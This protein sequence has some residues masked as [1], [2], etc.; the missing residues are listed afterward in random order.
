MTNRFERALAIA[1]FCLP[2]L[3]GPALALSSGPAMPEYNDFES[4]DNTDLVNLV[5]GDMA[6]TIPVMTVP[7]PGLGFPIVLNYHS[8]IQPEQEASWVG[9]GWNLEAGAIT[10]QVNNVPDDFRRTPI[11][12]KITS[13]QI[14]GWMASIAWNGATVGISWDSESGLGG[15]VGYSYGIEGAPFQVGGTAGVNGVY[16]GVGVTLGARAMSRVGENSA[17]GAG[18]NLGVHSKRGFTAGVSA[19]VSLTS[20]V[21]SGSDAVHTSTSLASVGVSLSSSKGPSAGASAGV[22]FTASASV[23][24][25]AQNS[26][27]NVWIPVW[28]PWTG[29][30]EFNF[31]TWESYIDGFQEDRYYGFLYSDLEGMECA[32]DPTRCYESPGDNYT[33]CRGCNAKL[34]LKK[35]D[36]INP[37]EYSRVPV[38]PQDQNTIDGISSAYFKLGYTGEDIYSVQTQGISGTFRPYRTEDGEYYSYV[39]NQDYAFT[40]GCKFIGG[41]TIGDC[42][43]SGTVEFGPFYEGG[44]GSLPAR[45]RHSLAASGRSRIV[46]RFND[47]RGGALYTDPADRGAA[48]R[49]AS[50][51]RRIE[52]IFVDN[53]IQGWRVTKSDGARYLYANAQYNYS[54]QTVASTTS[55]LAQSTRRETPSYAYAWLLTA[56]LSPDYVAVGDQNRTCLV[57]GSLCQPRDGDIGGW[58]KFTYSDP[59]TVTWKTPVDRGSDVGGWAPNLSPEN[60]VTTMGYKSLSYLDAIETPSHIATMQ[61]ADNS[62]KDGIPPAL[63]EVGIPI[64]T[65]TK[66]PP[67][68]QPPA[69]PKYCT[70]TEL[71]TLARSNYLV[72]IPNA[73]ETLPP[74]TQVTLVAR[75]R[76]SWTRFDCEWNWL[77]L[78]CGQFC[79]EGAGDEVVGNYV[80]PQPVGNTY[81]LR[82]ENSTDIESLR[83][84][85]GRLEPGQ[86]ASRLAYLRGITLKNKAFGTQ[87]Q[88]VGAVRFAYDYSLAQNTPNSESSKARG[89]GGDKGR[90]TLK[91]VQMGGTSQGPWTPPYTFAY[92]STLEGDGTEVK[93]H[94]ERKDYWGYQCNSC[95]VARRR[96][97]G[98]A[99]AW[100]LKRITHPS[101]SEIEF[102][103]EPKTA[104]YVE[105]VPFLIDGDDIGNHLGIHEDYPG[106]GPDH[107]NAEFQDLG[108][109][110]RSIADYFSGK[111]VMFLGRFE[112][113]AK[114]G[115][116]TDI[117]NFSRV[118]HHPAIEAFRAQN[119]SFPAPE[120]LVEGGFFPHSDDQFR[121]GYGDASRS[122]QLLSATPNGSPAQIVGQLKSTEF[123]PAKINRMFP[124]NAWKVRVWAVFTQRPDLRNYQ[125]G[126]RVSEVKFNEPFAGK[127]NFVR[128]KYEDAATP[129]LPESFSNYELGL[130]HRDATGIKAYLGCPAILHGKVTAAY[131]ID[132]ARQYAS[133]YN[134]VTSRDL[135]VLVNSVRPA[136]FVNG[137]PLQARVKILDRS[138]LW[139]SLWRKVDRDAGNAV[140]REATTS[141]SARLAEWR[142]PMLVRPNQALALSKD[143][144]A[145]LSDNDSQLKVAGEAE[146]LLPY[147]GITQKLWSNRFLPA[148]CHDENSGPHKRDCLND[149]LGAHAAQVELLRFSPLRRKEHTLQ[150][151]LLTSV[152]SNRFD[153][154][155]GEPL[156]SIS[157]NRTGGGIDEYIATL[158]APAFLQPGT[159]YAAMK[160]MNM[161]DQQFSKTVFRFTENPAGKDFA[162]LPQADLDRVV[163]SEVTPWIDLPYAMQGQGTFSRFRNAESFVLKDRAGFQL[164]VPGGLTP[165]K[166][167]NRGGTE[168]FD[169]FGHAL[170][171][172]S[173][174]GHRSAQVWG[175]RSTLP[176]AFAQNAK[177]DEIFYQGFETEE[178]R[179]VIRSGHAN[180]ALEKKWSRTGAASLRVVNC[181]EADG[182]CA[183]GDL[184]TMVCA[185]LTGLPLGKT[186][187]ASAW[188]YDEYKGSNPDNPLDE[189]YL[190][191]PI[192]VTRPGIFIG[193]DG[194]AAGC[195]AESHPNGAFLPS[196]G[197]LFVPPAGNNSPNAGQRALGGRNWKRVS[198]EFTPGGH[199]GSQGAMTQP[200]LCL[201][202][203]KGKAGSDVFYDEVRVRP[204]DA[205]MSTYAYNAR[206]KMSSSADANEVPT[207]YD[208]DA[209]GNLTGIRN[210]DGKLLNEQAKKHAEPAVEY[211]L[212]RAGVYDFGNL[213]ADGCEN[214]TVTSVPAG[215]D[216]SFTQPVIEPATAATFKMKTDNQG[217]QQPSL[218]Y[219]TY[220]PFLLSLNMTATGRTETFG[221]NGRGVGPITSEGCA[222]S[223]DPPFLDELEAADQGVCKELQFGTGERFYFIQDA[224]PTFAGMYLPTEAQF[225][226]AGKIAAQDALAGYRIRIDI[227]AGM[228]EGRSEPDE[229]PERFPFLMRFNY[230]DDIGSNYDFI[231]P[232]QQRAPSG[233]G[234]RTNNVDYALIP[235]NYSAIGTAFSVEHR[236]A[237]V[238]S[239][240]RL[241]L[242]PLARGGSAIPEGNYFAFGLYANGYPAGPT[243]YW[244]MR[245]S[246]PYAHSILKDIRVTVTPLTTFFPN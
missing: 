50:A 37:A 230:F 171:T 62:R 14:H 58:V 207:H 194:G 93:Y 226:A 13:Q 233:E 220:E 140:V 87:G 231:N 3:P 237:A 124:N 213:T 23:T 7:G 119:P 134:F 180:H 51:S 65:F 104:E 240:S 15:M 1:A 228:G 206:G 74:G 92:H 153:F 216:V 59:K 46:W 165:A 145:I 210:E 143:G 77:S 47:E 136:G 244:P 64:T 116:A 184:G 21:G 208:Y 217:R 246:D 148:Y 86:E 152:E 141:W 35:M 238:K 25:Q 219:L 168:R 138:G 139:G 212:H 112:G 222:E 94:R 164:P 91:A 183:P 32:A 187:V 33:R 130:K 156:L 109:I 192:K 26:S 88:E 69:T 235:G 122:G 236:R 129:T 227:P 105:G 127:S 11:E 67:G 224:K 76:I 147:F 45:D 188:Y 18:L 126:V 177:K 54:Q 175:Y 44:T 214:F 154:L 53:I 2:L 118:Q 123:S 113:R 114:G 60:W 49:V 100:N 43:R 99:N 81:S 200:V 106:H 239:F 185:D 181:R 179:A 225:K 39:S 95:D 144:K 142:A 52:P 161:L 163:T 167:Q 111:H 158:A 202:A 174:T 195:A 125:G 68:D 182:K 197:P 203:S 85:I 78:T 10:R 170:Q 186:Y 63:R 9:L 121:Y 42:D 241:Q 12:E 6:Y 31:G 201:Y 128:Y 48:P 38:T 120:Y 66:L 132:D 61:R 149:M 159:V 173:A 204:K 166:W 160:Q 117:Y 8:G 89:D 196:D 151:R 34:R 101:G 96:P 137:D 229:L 17:V 215:H 155:T 83:M 28:T 146:A 211:R 98:S 199:C 198:V 150:D 223:N 24:G 79:Q 102:A 234:T 178:E 22:G 110:Q 84:I 16:E 133:E 20:T 19:G 221:V 243:G 103:Y 80:L 209:F 57:G 135:P 172:R 205:L 30:I 157:R 232:P 115:P 191:K 75:R 189:S 218:C 108:S 82:I 190:L 4:I 40:G 29:Y 90:L 97:D 242:G 56:I 169:D 72:T 55:D 36:F 27:A 5:T 71:H 193:T 162:A 176:T 41:Y 131:R 107:R 245:L 73:A 70:D